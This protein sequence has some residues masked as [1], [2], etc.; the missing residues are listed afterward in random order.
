MRISTIV[1]CVGMGLGSTAIPAM[2]APACPFDAAN[3]QFKGSATDQAKCLL[4]PV[5]IQGNVGSEAALPTSLAQTVGTDAGFKAADLRA[6]LAPLHISESEL[7]GSFDAP[8]SRAKAGSPGAPTA[9]YFVIHDTSSPNLKSAPFPSS[10]NDVS[11]SGNDLMRWDTGPAAKA[12]LFNN[13][14]GQSLTAVDLGR[15]WRAT[16]FELS[17]GNLDPKGLFIHVENIQPRRALNGKGDAEAP[18]PGFSGAQYERLAL[19]YA[20][21]SLRK[22]SWLIPAFHCVLDQGTPGDHDDPQN[23]DLAAW[24]SAIE[25]LRT[26]LSG[27]SAPPV[28]AGSP[29][30]AEPAAAPVPATESGDRWKKT[31]FAVRWYVGQG[32]PL[33][34]DAVVEA[35]AGSA[36]QPD[37]ELETFSIRYYDWTQSVP[38]APGLTPILRERIKGSDDDSRYQLTYKLRSDSPY[39]GSEDR[40]LLPSPDDSK[41][42]VDASAISGSEFRRTYSYSCTVANAKAPVPL[43]AG[44]PARTKPCTA[45]MTRTSFKS[46]GKV[47][48]EVWDLP[49]EARMIEVSRSGKSTAEAQAAFLAEIVAPLVIGGIRPVAEGKTALAGACP[50]ANAAS[51]DTSENAFKKLEDQ[52]VPVKMAFSDGTDQWESAVR[53]VR[54]LPSGVILVRVRHLS[55]DTDGASA[56]VRACD[57]TAQ[58]ATSL[59]DPTGKPTD[60]NAIGYF[61]LPDCTKDSGTSCKTN[62]PETQLRLRLGNLAAVIADGHLAYAIAADHGSEK[63]ISEGSVELHRQLGHETVGKVP[64]KPQCAANQ[65]LE[66][67]TLLAIFP[68]SGGKWRPQAEI[69]TSGAALWA[70]LI[71]KP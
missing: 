63:H 2:A 41:V 60:A 29:T 5:L 34:A 65:S 59:S 43:P 50:T 19:L 1:A 26:K 15:P 21:A 13:R 62:R 7:G 27:A 40:C 30:M 66:K 53:S 3:L 71:S 10:I 52:A 45:A 33:T 4:R 24:A 37:K 25:R 48:V 36:T 61:V 32:G 18:K 49:G 56:E 20:A 11:W 44:I 54:K 22:G 14:V 9:R 68:N 70:E 35:L 8:L 57:K 17:Y 23:F 42:E 38:T 64:S 28:V 12:H 51:T 46:G 6:Y 58:A 47:K 67:E 31:E 16:Q 39:A 55:L 69:E